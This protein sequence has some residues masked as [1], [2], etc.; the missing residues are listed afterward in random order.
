MWLQKC[1][2][3]PL[4]Y[5]RVV[6]WLHPLSGVL[7]PWWMRAYRS[8]RAVWICH[9]QHGIDA[10]RSLLDW[11]ISC[12]AWWWRLQQWGLVCGGG[13][14][15]SALKAQGRF[16]RPTQSTMPWR[17]QKE[18]RWAA[19]PVPT[20]ENTGAHVAARQARCGGVG[21][22]AAACAA[23]PI[24]VETTVLFFEIMPTISKPFVT[25]C[26]QH[27]IQCHHGSAAALYVL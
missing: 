13:D 3:V 2:V 11:V 4:S 22:R 17:H 18:C 7:R 1:P 27:T 21:A 15:G 6:P 19:Y 25:T 16:C 20:T 23:H 5:C 26:P 9:V 10:L 14:G 24:P 8:A 12:L